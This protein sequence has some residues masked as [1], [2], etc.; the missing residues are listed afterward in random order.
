MNNPKQLLRLHPKPIY[1]ADVTSDQ[2]N[3]LLE[4]T[5][6]TEVAAFYP[7]IFAKFL[8]PEKISQIIISPVSGGGS[9]GGGGGGG[10]AAGGEEGAA[11]SKA[12]EIEEVE[13]A[14]PAVDSE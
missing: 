6:N 5:G 1:Q 11:E 10:A 8:T 2:I 7:I 9:G 13:E 4:A 14:P 12:A 3:T